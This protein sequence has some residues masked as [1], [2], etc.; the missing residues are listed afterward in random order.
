VNSPPTHAAPANDLAPVSDVGDC[1]SPDGLDLSGLEDLDSVTMRVTGG[2]ISGT[3]GAT[4]K[5]HKWTLLQ[6][7]KRFCT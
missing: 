3:S 6:N 7:A 1:M 2:I 5:Y 4:R